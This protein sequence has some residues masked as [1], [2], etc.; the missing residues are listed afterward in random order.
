ML[1]YTVLQ[2]IEDLS[3]D[4]TSGVYLVYKK[5]CLAEFSFGVQGKY[6]DSVTARVAAESYVNGR[7]DSQSLR[8]TYIP[9]S[10]LEV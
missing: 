10:Y 9:R 1:N 7:K 3:T 4:D 6:K 8:I 2:P 5:N